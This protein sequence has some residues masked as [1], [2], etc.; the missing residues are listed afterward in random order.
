[1]NSYHSTYKRDA[2]LLFLFFSCK[3]SLLPS[4]FSLVNIQVSYLA[5]QFAKFLKEFEEETPHGIIKKYRIQCVRIIR[6]IHK[7]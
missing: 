6:H 2:G 7:Q 3:R 5:E 1:M 4:P